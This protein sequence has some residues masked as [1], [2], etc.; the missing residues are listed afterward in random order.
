MKAFKNRSNDSYAQFNKNDI[1]EHIFDVD[2]ST[3]ISNTNTNTNTSNVDTSIQSTNIDSSQQNVSITNTNTST[4][5]SN[6]TSNSTAIDN[7][8]V[9]NIS[10][11]SNTTNVDSSTS[12]T[13]ND[14]SVLTNNIVKCGL[15][16]SGA[17][18]LVANI[19][20]SINII[21]NASNSFIA[22][23]NNNTISDVKLQSM[24]QSYGPTID[25][26]CVQ[27]AVTKS[28][29]QQTARNEANKST[30]GGINTFGLKTGGNTT[31]TTNITVNEQGSKTGVE[32]ISAASGE[33][34]VEAASGALQKTDNVITTDNQTKQSTTAGGLYDGVM[35]CVLLLIFVVVLYTMEEN[36]GSPY[37]TAMMD[38]IHQNQLLTLI[39]LGSGL[40][41]FFKK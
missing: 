35:F 31:E 17:K 12:S 6:I 7:S 25:K 39:V 5:I 34:V 22:T 2:V 30:S 26:K 21:N 1:I 36:G 38:F 14:S 18:D 41:Y 19:N 10:S 33:S 9:S 40:Y 8:T 28:L 24:L 13:V 29:A 3:S 37:Y 20:D 27:E 4:D 32:S 16:A 11:V 23:G 15:D